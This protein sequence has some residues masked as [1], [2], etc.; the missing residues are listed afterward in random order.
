MNNTN[1]GGAVGMNM[2]DFVSETSS[3]LTATNLWQ[4]VVPIA[5]MLGVLI[6]FSVGIYFLRKAIKGAG[7]GKAKI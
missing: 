4:Q 2:T 7:K 3:Q 5:S 6:L 1:T